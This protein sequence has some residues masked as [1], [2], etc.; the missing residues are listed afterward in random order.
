M[1][2]K[3]NRELLCRVKP[4]AGSNDLKAVGSLCD[5]TIGVHTGKFKR[6]GSLKIIENAVNAGL[7]YSVDVVTKVRVMNINDG[8]SH[9][10]TGEVGSNKRDLKVGDIFTLSPNGGDFDVLVNRLP[11]FPKNEQE[12]I[13][14]FGDDD[15]LCKVVAHNDK[16][17]K[18]EVISVK[19][20]KCLFANHGI[21]STSHDIESRDIL[22]SQID[23]ELLLAIPPEHLKF[24]KEIVLSFVSN[25]KQ[26][27]EAKQELVLLG[28]EGTPV[29]AK[30]ETGK[31][32]NN[33]EEIAKVAD[34]IVIGCGDLQ[35][36][37]ERGELID[38]LDVVLA[39]IL[40]RLKK[41]GYS[42]DVF[43]ACGIGDAVTEKYNQTSVLNHFSS[44]T[45]FEILSWDLKLGRTVNYWMTYAT[46]GIAP[47]MLPTLIGRF[48]EDWTLFKD[49]GLRPE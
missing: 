28:F 1:S 34:K 32:V 15:V 4:D 22:L 19:S 14:V 36:A 3:F 38:G 25:A 16:L 29:V 21:S 33:L 37:C 10:G 23:K 39:D 43:V 30:I 35:K 48:I 47:V 13:L 44:E 27:V 45:L 9:E 24:L 31:G 12:K 8:K 18:L 46:V 7:Q 49:S 26:F 17:I 42:G 41:S 40:Q 6:D 20:G 2:Y 5:L 11:I